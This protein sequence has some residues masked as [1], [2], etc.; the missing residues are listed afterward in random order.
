MKSASDT[1]AA[2]P[3]ERAAWLRAEIERHNRLYYV[4]A[5]TEISDV[6]FDALV[7]ELEDL[8]AAHPELAT[9]DS[10][11]RKVWGEP[12]AGFANVQH[13]VPMLSIRNT[14]NEAEVRKFD[15]DVRKGVGDEPVRYVVEL[16][17][18]GVAMSMTFTNGVYTAA[19]TR[20]DGTTGDDVTQN[21][22]TLRDLPKQ[23]K[24]APAGTVEVRGEVFMERAE[25]D[26]LNVLREA[27]GEEPYRNPRNTTA[28]TL[29]LLDPAQVAKRHLRLFVYEMVPVDFK[30]PGTHQ[31]TLKTL[32]AWGLPVN[33]HFT[34]CDSIEE[35]LALCD[36]WQTK[37]FDL[38]YETDGL[39]VKV[40]KEEQ[41]AKL[42]YTS[43]AP[44]WVMAYK[45]PAEVRRTR[46]NDIVFQVGK[47]G[48][49]TPVAEL[50]P[51]PLAGTIVKRATLHNFEELRRKDLR[52]GDLVEVQKAG[53]IIP[54]VLG[55]VPEERPESAPAVEP[56]EACPSCGGALHQDPEGV[57]LRCLNLACPAQI[58]GRLTHFASRGAMD[59]DGLGPA[60]IEQ[61][62]SREL[63]T[64]PVDLYALEADILAGL[65]R[66]G[67]KSAAN[68][69][70]AIEASKARPLARLLFGLGI[71]HVGTTTATAL[72]REFKNMDA[73]MAA[74]VDDLEAVDDVGPIVAS[75]V[76]DFFDTEAN[77][78]L[79]ET[80]RMAGLNMEQPVETVASDGP[81]TGKTLVVTGT[82]EG[83]TRDEMHEAIQ[84][85][86]GK[87][88]SSVSK[89]TD[90][91]VAGE[92]AGSKLDKAE[93]LGVTVLTEQ[94][95][96]AM[97]EGGA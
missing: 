93:K 69:V 31:D 57:F 82:L 85:A 38:P 13:R 45:F 64:T 8:E 75:S 58:L 94:E 18:D 41:R 87:V 43:K 88:A 76:A 24:D 42:G 96:L 91:L 12:L 10:P 56:P 3:A 7:R 37:R 21:I 49:V 59:I 65:E 30:K 29:K 4:E 83:M 20:G 19:A 47:S 48:V 74:K 25:L 44:K 70:A 72:A 73:L 5:E 1:A 14:Y 16:K 33:D 68:L 71:R 67:E 39:V 60:I 40:D 61:L 97:L 50:E 53:E 63:V 9:E 32:A 22:A 86:G 6:D 26:R 92:K 52:K 95:I 55:Y 89:K 90:Y 46:L 78:A 15:Q 79:V 80:L 27:A 35:V 2:S 62:V 54:Q 51:V 34:V 28:G 77:R 17:M 66:M 11:T 36:S 84:R 23:L 81:L